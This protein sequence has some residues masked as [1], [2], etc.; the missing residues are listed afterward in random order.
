MTNNTVLYIGGFQLP[1]K[2]AAAQRV[3]GI[4]K[5]LRLLGY[6]V[7]FLNSLTK[8][9]NRNIKCK[10]YFGFT[11]YEF[12]REMKWDYLISGKTTLSLIK[13]I[14]PATIIAYNYPA[15]SLNRIRVFCR[16]NN[17][18]LYADC[19]EWYLAEGRGVVYRLIK[20]V[21]T[22]YRMR[23]VHKKLDG[24]I[25]ISKYLYNYY[26]NCV[27]TVLI[28]P[29]IDIDDSKWAVDVQK[30]ADISSFIYA[31]S[32]SL[33][34]EDL[35]YIVK[36]I[37]HVSI[38]YNVELNVVGITDKQFIKMYNWKEQIPTS[39]R[40]IG[41]VNHIDVVKM[42]SNSDWS[43]IL[44]GNNRVVNAGFPTKVVEAISCGTPVIV[45]DFSNIK[46]YLDNSNS[47]VIKDYS[48]LEN[49][50][51]TA[52]NRKMN[53]NKGLFD[54]RNYLMELNHLLS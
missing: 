47:I 49:A 14:K 16:K 10:D 17:I 43:I 24:I 44:R 45:N 39:V 4:A 7:V 8:C 27:N 48:E 18:K 35:D 6:N 51:I 26:C 54:Y 37:D 30:E 13:S 11:C 5:G 53:V 20:N 41:R 19:T 34:K 9:D 12:Q 38:D 3:V 50:I 23:V 2:N 46:D 42:V 31:G 36:T 22:F 25:A 40:F 52:I 15:L 21:D 33:L 29:T 1:D 32:P 28:P